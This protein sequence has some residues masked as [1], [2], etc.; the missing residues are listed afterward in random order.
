MKLNIIKACSDLGVHINGSNNGPK[1]L[2][3]FDNLVDNVYDI[4]K[5]KTFKELDKNNKKKN[6]KALNKFNEELYNTIIKSKENFTITLGGDHSITIASALASKKKHKNIGVIWIDSHSD[7]HDLKT[8]ISGNI[9]GMPFATICNQN[10]NELS[11]FFDEEYFNPHNAVLVGARDI[12]TDEYKKLKEAEIKIFTTKDIQ[13]KGTENIMKQAIKIA[14][15]NTDGIH[16]SY[17][18]DVIDPKIAPGVSVKAKDGI[19]EKEAFEILDEII[20]NK[21]LIKSFDLVE[22]N[23]DYDID[24]K[25]EIIANKILKNLINEIKKIN[26]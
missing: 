15:N 11:Y 23:P 5:E 18:L 12:E 16:I 6:I 21:E 20:K 8:T 4:N 26:D 3:K 9:H 14:K 10:G 7:F 22:F 1:I 13:E 19:T 24:N 25:T 17:D 2:N